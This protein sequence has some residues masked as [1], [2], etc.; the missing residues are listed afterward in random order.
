MKKQV[1]AILMSVLLSFNQLNAQEKEKI[2]WNVGFQLNQFQSDFGL[3]VNV[4]FPAIIK[5]AVVIRLRA[6]MMFYEHVLAGKTDWTTYSNVMLGFSSKKYKVAEFLAMYGEGGVIG[7]LPSSKFS[8]SALDIGGY[9]IFGFEFFFA[10]EFNYFI[11]LGGV[12]TG[13]V[14]D[15]LIFEPIYSNGFLVSVGWR[16]NF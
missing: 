10:P 6:N 7:I 9:G 5:D 14:A 8:S 4:A 1:F 12:G 3:G 16:I 13:A 15:R 2:E 11:E